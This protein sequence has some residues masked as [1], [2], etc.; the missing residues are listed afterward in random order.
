MS[1]RGRLP[2]QTSL[3][4]QA[5][6]YY[7]VWGQRF[8]LFM[9]SRN[10]LDAKNIT[11]MSPGNAFTGPALRGND[12]EIYYT[13]TGRTGGAYLDDDTNGDGIEDFVPLNDPR[14]YGD[15]R[16]VRVGVSFSF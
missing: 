5:E 4:I 10:V 16:S 7:Q 11:D 12:Y 3:D 15:P 1:T 2:G 6:K 9:Q 13:E 8:K 14:V